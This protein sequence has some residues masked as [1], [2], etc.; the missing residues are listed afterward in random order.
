MSAEAGS[1]NEAIHNCRSVADNAS[2]QLHDIADALSRVGMDHLARELMHIANKIVVG[3]REVSAAYGIDLSA[4]LAQ[5]EAM[6]G[7]L[8]KATL[9]GCIVPPA[10]ATS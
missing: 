6:M 5:S 3:P 4:Q 9:A 7:N 1:L 2:Y 10:K 8:L